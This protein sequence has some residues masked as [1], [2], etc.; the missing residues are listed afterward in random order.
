M[1]EPTLQKILR[2]KYNIDDRLL[3]E[4]RFVGLIGD[5]GTNLLCLGLGIRCLAIARVVLSGDVIDYEL[6]SLLPLAILS[7]SYQNLAQKIK[8]SKYVPVLQHC[9][10]ITV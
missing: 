7:L 2:E 9:W 10:H 5:H 8:V 3:A 1:E 6:L 4:G